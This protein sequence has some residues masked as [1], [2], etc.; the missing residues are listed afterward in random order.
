MGFIFS[1]YSKGIYVDGHERENVVAYRK[2]FLESI[3]KYVF[4]NRFFLNLT[5][6]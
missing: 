6:N 4:L 2:E 5:F 3:A 1:Y